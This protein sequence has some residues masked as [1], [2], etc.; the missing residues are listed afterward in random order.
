MLGVSGDGVHDRIGGRD[1]GEVVTAKRETATEALE[2][3]L[4][5]QNSDQTVRYIDSPMGLLEIE[6]LRRL[7]EQDE[8][9]GP[10][11]FLNLFRE[12]AS[13]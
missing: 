4:A 2:L 11:V 7:V 6:T 1:G 5:L 13:A 8:R 9:L 3:V 10:S 12:I